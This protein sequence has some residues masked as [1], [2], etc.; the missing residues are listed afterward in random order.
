MCF[1]SLQLLVVHI[2]LQVTAVPLKY[3][4]HIGIH[5]I[6]CL[7]GE[8]LLMLRDKIKASQ[9]YLN[10][11]ALQISEKVAMKIVMKCTLS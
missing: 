7:T 1:I 6:V 4:C 11:T 5:L 8:N 9:K 3:P 2:C 10:S